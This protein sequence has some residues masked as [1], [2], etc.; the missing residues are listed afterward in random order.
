M[1]CSDPV[2]CLA[3][4]T[5]VIAFVKA[6]GWL[7]AVSA[8]YWIGMMFLGEQNDAENGPDAMPPQ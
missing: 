1:A 6:F 8:L 3:V 4:K 7:A 2:V 5:A